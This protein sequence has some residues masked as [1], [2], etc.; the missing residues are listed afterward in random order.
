MNKNLAKTLAG[1]CAINLV[2]CSQSGGGSN[3]SGQNNNPPAPITTPANQLKIVMAG[4]IPLLNG[5]AATIDAI[6]YNTSSLAVNNPQ[7]SLSGIN[8]A[9]ITSYNGCDKV[10]APNSECRVSLQFNAMKNTQTALSQP[11]T[12]KYINHYGQ[13]KATSMLYNAVRVTPNGTSPKL[14]NTSMPTVLT[15]IG[16]GN[17]RGV[18]YVVVQNPNQVPYSLKDTNFSSGAFKVSTTNYAV[19]NQ[20]NNG[21]LLEVEYEASK[22]TAL[23][24]TDLQDGK[25]GGFSKLLLGDS[26]GASLA[27]NTTSDYISSG[28]LVSGILNPIDSTAS[29]SE[30]LVLTN[31]G[32]TDVSNISVVDSMGIITFNNV[33]TTVA[34]GENKI[35]NVVATPGSSGSPNV[36]ISSSS[37]SVTQPVTIYAAPQPLVVVQ[38]L[39]YL[40]AATV[41]QT[42]AVTLKN[43]SNQ[44]IHVNDVTFTKDAGSAATTIEPSGDGCTGQSIP[45]GS[46][47][48][49]SSL[50]INSDVDE[51][52]SSVIVNM[53]Y[54][55]NG[56]NSTV[57]LS[58]IGRILYQSVLRNSVSIAA[59]SSF[60]VV[61]NNLAVNY[62]SV[63]ITNT[64][65]LHPITIESWVLSNNNSSSNWLKINSNGNCG[66]GTELLPESANSCTFG[67]SLGPVQLN[68]P[69]DDINSTESLS[70]S[71]KT[72]PLTADTLTASGLVPF[73]VTLGNQ[74]YLTLDSYTPANSASGTGTSA[75]PYQF[76]G[77]A[78]GSSKTVALKFVN[79]SGAPLTINNVQHLANPFYWAQATNTCTGTLNQN[80]S[81]TIS[82]YDSLYQNVANTTQSGPN[83]V[84][85]LILPEFI[86][87]SQST[88]WTFKVPSINPNTND[89][90]VYSNEGILLLD[91]SVASQ[92]SN[93][94]LVNIIT[95]AL[96]GTSD[97]LSSYSFVESANIAANNLIE[98][99][100]YT[101]YNNSSCTVTPDAN[102]MFNQACTYNSAINPYGVSY[103][104]TTRGQAGTSVGLNTAYYITPTGNQQA[105][106]QK[107]NYFTV[108]VN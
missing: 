41:G 19:G 33:P 50:T 87:T 93:N 44:A 76:R 94:N 75:D 107:Q 96:V 1:L 92:T 8:N 43:M 18:T 95:Q 35:I 2:A 55:Y 26:L 46:T 64:S 54:T 65:T 37:N 30:Q 48:T 84:N 23:N 106:S 24:K 99:T 17:V 16:N 78:A 60:E 39:S 108:N 98:S 51:T 22:S 79:T 102:G 31:V 83:I 90:T 25:N 100:G 27:L 104:S 69:G 68:N 59:P 62:E 6:I 82:Y 91:H 36:V 52:L 9:K 15:D 63:V 45:A 13:Q 14:I 61:G 77:S 11:L 47:C 3:G 12:V 40:F 7:F 70:V 10:I 38:N 66:I 28:Y 89:N 101:Q 88:S 58:P 86:V 56:G 73:Q 103:L 53:G 57:S 80:E 5:G 97:D 4:Q 49:I 85:N 105:I 72:K 20:L 32:T 67:V 34:G 42:Q 29:Q 71:F 21:A 81:C 74:A